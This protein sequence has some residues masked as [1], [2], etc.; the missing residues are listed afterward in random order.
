MSVSVDYYFP[1]LTISV[2]SRILDDIE[3]Y[4]KQSPFS[5]EDL[6]CLSRFVNEFAFRLIWNNVRSKMMSDIKD[7]VTLG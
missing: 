2:F 5:L 7:S 3:L 6:V 1:Y 4:E